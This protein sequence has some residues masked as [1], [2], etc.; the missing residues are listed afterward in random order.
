MVST[1]VQSYTRVIP[2]ELLLPALVTMM[3]VPEQ[4]LLMTA[5]AHHSLCVLYRTATQVPL[6]DG[7]WVD[8]DPAARS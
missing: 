6:L 5:A 2:A 3:Q 7:I 8:V 4:N 1:N